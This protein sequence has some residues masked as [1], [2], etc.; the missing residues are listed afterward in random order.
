MNNYRKELELARAVAIEAGKIQL[1]KQGPQLKVDTKSDLS[2]VTEVDKA[3]EQFI[4]RK[5]LDTFP[6]DGFLGEETGL[7]KG[8]NSRRWIVDPLDGTRPYIRGIPTYSVLIALED[9]EL[10]DIIVGVAHLPALDQTY[11]AAAGKGAYCNE[12]RINVS[13]MRSIGGAMCSVLGIIDKRN[14][15]LG[16]SLLN[17]AGACDYTYGYMD[18]YS[19]C[20]V[21]AG[22]MDFSVNLLDK[23]WDCAAAACI[24]TQAGG[25]YSDIHGRKSVHNGSFVMTNGYLHDEVLSHF[26]EHSITGTGDL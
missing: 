1:D 19:Y 18:A 12:E 9:E 24:V 11:Y 21:A 8:K 6:D 7:L 5:L 15:E 2:P 20:S 25:Q 23:A 3:C 13:H 10:E 22:R 17:L 16:V 14:T 4:R 26:A